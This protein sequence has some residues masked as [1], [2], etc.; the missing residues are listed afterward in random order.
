VRYVVEITRKAGLA[1]PEGT[2]TAAALADLGYGEV[3]AVHF[4][5]TIL[6]EVS[7][8]TGPDR[9][10]EMCRKLLAN[11]VIEDYRVEVEG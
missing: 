5:R 2:T 9:I 3:V 1:D 4:G 7:D 11:P 8:G 10:D 6:L